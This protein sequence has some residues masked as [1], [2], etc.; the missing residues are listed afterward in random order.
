MVNHDLGANTLMGAF[1]Q[2]P[3]TSL[4]VGGIFSFYQTHSTCKESSVLEN[5]H[6]AHAVEVWLVGVGRKLVG[7]GMRLLTLGVTFRKAS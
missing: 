6:L 5:V 1:S 7:P 2:K 4:I 3:A